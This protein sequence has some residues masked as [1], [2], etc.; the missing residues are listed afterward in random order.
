MGYGPRVHLFP[1][2]CLLGSAAGQCHVLQLAEKQ[3]WW[4]VAVRETVPI[5]PDFTDIILSAIKKKKKQTSPGAGSNKFKMKK[6]F[7]GEDQ[8]KEPWQSNL[9]W[10]F[11]R[12]CAAVKYDYFFWPKQSDSVENSPGFSIPKGYLCMLSNLYCANRAWQGLTPSIP[13]EKRKRKRKKILFTK[14][15]GWGGQ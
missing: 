9:S 8:A 14:R 13:R 5:K 11:S 6:A 3:R 12:G 7:K 1:C 2:I 10:F 15:K 4:E